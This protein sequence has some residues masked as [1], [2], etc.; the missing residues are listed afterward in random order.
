MKYFSAS[1]GFVIGLYFTMYS[2]VKMGAFDTS[3]YIQSM[4]SSSE[5]VE[6]TT[7]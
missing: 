4:K 6:K 1:I 2:A 3:I 5:Y 7:L